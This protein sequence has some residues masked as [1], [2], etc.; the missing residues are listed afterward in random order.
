MLR[1]L[2]FVFP[3]VG[4]IAGVLNGCGIPITWGNARDCWDPEDPAYNDPECAGR[5]AGSDVNVEEDAGSSTSSSGLSA[6]CS[7]TCVPNEPN[8]FDDPQPVYF[9]SKTGQYLT[10]PKELGEFGGMQYFGLNI[11]SPGCP[12]CVC[13]S[14]KGSCFPPTTITARAGTCDELQPAMVDFSGPQNWD[15]SCTNVNALPAGA[16]CPLAS[17]VLCAQSIDSTNL[18]P[19]TQGCEP[20]PV[21]VPKATNDRPWWSNFVLSCSSS[22]ML[23][24]CEN[25]ASTTC[26]PALPPN[27]P[28]WRY[29]VRA[30]MPGEQICPVGW[31]AKFTK[32]MLA[33]ENYIDTR[34]CTECECHPSGGA[35]YGTLRVYTDDSCSS[36]ELFSTTL[37]SDMTNCENLLPPGETLGSK[38]FTDVMYMPGKCE[39]TGGMPVGGVELDTKTM[40]TWCCLESANDP[41]AM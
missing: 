13:G 8:G 22:A 18:P 39:P 11:P 15:G 1:R 31:G 19:P 33:Y 16:E 24:T 7:G 41:N 23:E 38:E 28:G 36:N 26:L 37:S 30:Q 29:C 10:C 34:T 32:Q 17:G 4:L 2:V 12:S 25:A 3:F 40:V 27:E 6:R 35:C 14:I 9:G 20:I 21:P 5:D